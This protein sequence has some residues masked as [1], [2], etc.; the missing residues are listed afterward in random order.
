MILVSNLNKLS[1]DCD[2]KISFS[3][4]LSRKEE[5]DAKTKLKNPVN[6][7]MPRPPIWIRQMIIIFP[8]GVKN[9]AVSTTIR[10]VTHTALTEVKNESRKVN[11]RV[12]AF[13][14][15][16]KPEPIKMM[17][18]KLELK[19]KAGG[20]FME[21]TSL[22]STDISEIA[23]RKIAI[24]TGIFPEK[25]VQ[26]EMLLFTIPKFD[27]KTPSENRK[28]IIS[29]NIDNIVFFLKFKNSGRNFEKKSIRNNILN[30][31]RSLNI[32][33]SVFITPI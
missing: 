20:T 22:A 10:P 28:T 12:W 8:R 23:M 2:E 4:S 32:S 21:L 18:R 15:I 26:K 5:L 7:I 1:N 33:S 31:T 19:S 17:I 3:N 6:V 14:N 29:K 13:G 9:V 16:N 27:S 25:N 11:G 30:A 24:V